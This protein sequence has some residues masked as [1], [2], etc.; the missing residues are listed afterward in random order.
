MK[1]EGS[2]KR[3]TM[4]DLFLVLLLFLCVAGGLIRWLGTK[5]SEAANAEQQFLLEFYSDGVDSMIIDCLREGEVLY[6]T[7]GSTFG[8]L[9]GIEQVPLSV[10]L[11]AGGEEIFGVWEPDRKCRVHITAR[12]TG[13]TREGMLLL[14]GKIPL[15]IGEKIVLRTRGSELYYRLYQYHSVS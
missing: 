12:C 5:S 2:T 3:G 1:K 7:D 14:G 9:A 6:Q 13:T 10:S 11:T 8:T 4:L 15:G